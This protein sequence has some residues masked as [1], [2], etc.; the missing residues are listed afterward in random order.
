MID[1]SNV[2]KN[3]SIGGNGGTGGDSTSANNAG[4]NGGTG[5]ASRAGGIYSEGNVRVINGSN[6]SGNCAI[7]GQGGAAGASGSL[8]SFAP[9]GGEGG[10]GQGGGIFCE[11]DVIVENS[12]VSNNK[13]KGGKG[14][15]GASGGPTGGDGG[16]G[17]NG[18]GGGIYGGNVSLTN[19]NV[20]LNTAIGGNGGNGGNGS[21]TG[22]TGGNGGDA[23][24]GGVFHTGTFAGDSRL[25]QHRHSGPGRPGR[26]THLRQRS[27]RQR[28]QRRRRS[29]TQGRPPL[30]LDVKP[31]LSRAAGDALCLTAVH[32][33]RIAQ[34]RPAGS[35]PVTGRD[36]VRDA[37]AVR[38]HVG[39]TKRPPK[40]ILR[41]SETNLLM[42][43]NA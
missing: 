10:D 9:A 3:Q 42:S 17:G 14:G 4:G 21:T 11:N 35:E 40:R 6:V 13:A 24:G 2:T 41:L 28:R 31:R 30:Q 7:G 33:G 26:L 34:T 37:R 16:N 22:G 25:Q 18:E 15:N 5:G 8:A 23:S 29:V 38:T 39:L 32:K 1:H 19:A 36:G 27:Q 12:T 20:F 43:S